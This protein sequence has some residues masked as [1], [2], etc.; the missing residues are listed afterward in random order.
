MTWSVHDGIYR[1]A[2]DGTRDDVL[3]TKESPGWP[4]GAMLRMDGG[5]LLGRG[6]VLEGWRTVPGWQPVTEPPGGQ[7]LQPKREGGAV[8]GILEWDGAAAIPLVDGALFPAGAL[9]PGGRAWVIAEPDPWI[10]N[11]TLHFWNQPD[12]RAPELQLS[13]RFTFHPT[14]FLASADGFAVW[15]SSCPPNAHC[16]HSHPIQVHWIRNGE[17]P[18]AEPHHGPGRLPVDLAW[19]AYVDARHVVAGDVIVSSDGTT[20]KLRHDVREAAPGATWG[21]DADGRLWTISYDDFL[22]AVEYG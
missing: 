3:V 8:T 10:G 16:S 4:P 14:G 13:D 7:W 17:P 5:I 20:G 2:V 19:A 18:E 11:V 15:G 21:I 1:R 12:G 22:M 9:Y 6:D